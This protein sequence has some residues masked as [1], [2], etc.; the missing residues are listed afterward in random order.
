M[1]DGKGALGLEVIGASAGSGKTYTI[2]ET[3][4]QAVDPKHPGSI[5]PDSLL[6][7]TFT[8]RAADELASRIRRKLLEAGDLEQAQRLPAA[9]LGTVHGVCFRLLQEYSLDAGLVPGVEVLADGKSKHLRRIVEQTLPIHLKN[10]MGEL[11]RS[12]QVE[13]DNKN[14]TSNWLFKVYEILD[15]MRG[16]DIAQKH[17]KAM[18]TRAADELLALLPPPAQDDLDGRLERELEKAVEDVK[19]CIEAG[20][21][22]KATGEALAAMKKASPTGEHRDW[23]S[24]PSLT[25]LKPGKKTAPSVEE[26]KEVAGRFTE[27]PRFH[28]DLREFIEG[29]YLA[30]ERAIQEYSEWK[31]R[32]GIVDYVDML[33]RALSLVEEPTVAA[34]LKEKLSLVVVDEFQD[35]SPIQ[36]SLFVKLHGIAG[37]SH[38]VGD[39]KQCIFEFA[40]ADPRLMKQV[41]SWTEKEGGSAR[42]LPRNYRSRPGLVRFCSELFVSALSAYGYSR[43]EVAVEPAREEPAGLEALPEIG[44]WRLEGKNKELV[45]GALA[46]GI[47]KLLEDPATTPVQDRKTGL[48]RPLKAG[49]IAVLVRDNISARDVSAA[50]SALGIRVAIPRPGLVST[51]EGCLLI[52]GLSLLVDPRD[53]HSSA[54]LDALHGWNGVGRAAW[55][56]DRISTR[57]SNEEPKVPSPWGHQMAGVQKLAPE[58]SPR[59]AVLAVIDALDAPSLAARWPQPAQRLANLDSLRALASEYENLCASDGSACTL[60]GLL[61]YLRSAAEVSWDGE[62]MTANDDQAYT[63][64]DGAVVITTYH[65]SKGLEWPVVILNS[66]DKG[67]RNDAF[68]IHLESDEPE[69]DPDQPLRGR[70]IRYWPN[71]FSSSKTGFHEAVGKHRYAHVA[72]QEEMEE[73]ARLLYV[74]ATRAR[75]HLIF[76]TRTDKRGAP[77]WLQE[78]ADENGPLLS[79]DSEHAVV[80]R[81]QADDAVRVPCRNWHLEPIEEGATAIEEGATAIESA[82]PRLFS[83]HGSP[84][85]E[86]PLYRVAP[87]SAEESW[88]EVLKPKLERKVRLGDPLDLLR[89]TVNWGA[90]GSAL[91]GFLACD[92]E[93]LAGEERVRRA[94]RLMKALGENRALSTEATT[95]AGDRLRVFVEQ[96]YPGAIW[97]RETSVDALVPT[98]SGTRRVGG[99]ID[100]LLETNDGLIVVDHKSFPDPTERHMVEVA[101]GYAGQLGAYAAALDPCNTKP[102]TECWIHFPIGG[103]MVGGRL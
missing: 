43:D 17:L 25:R 55:M 48:T 47:Q 37:R 66:L 29:V 82:A 40:G 91:H 53:P 36:L 30:A 67:P 8:T 41:L 34:D 39:R 4:A 22:T 93:G 23:N 88:P 50:L 63:E 57:A 1:R 13:W 11:A 96:H 65:R 71:L 10:R 95:L 56:A 97:H 24:W 81:Q 94:E 83:S 38:W 100:L 101:Q 78:L 16:N 6:G 89:K 64:D 85:S 61:S 2:T 92:V 84:R 28:A 7:V 19:A 69:F 99:I 86:A 58:L 54:V 68:G 77:V 18:G 14:D 90:L 35:T 62:E 60:I 102:V 44:H 12:L 33:Q 15:L 20:D 98:D 45:A 31:E 59:E 32:K 5:A 3:V 70:W 42:H 72:T 75:D 49:D 79:F 26:L 27:H 46:R 51:P 103:L 52:A 80:R 76:A 21:G 9:Y 73:R 87:S 74:G